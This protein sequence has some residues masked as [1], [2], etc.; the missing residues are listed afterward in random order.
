[1][2]QL[3]GLGLSLEIGV[4]FRRLEIVAGRPLELALGK[5]KNVESGGAKA[6]DL[7]AGSLRIE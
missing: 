7:L 1:M 2:G 3:G 6:E 5:V 4:V